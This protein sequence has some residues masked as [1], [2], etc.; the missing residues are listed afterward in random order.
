MKYISI[1]YMELRQLRYLLA[2]VRLGSVGA[3]AA[4]NFVTQPAVSLQLKKLEQEIGEKLLVRSRGRMVPTPTG[5]LVAAHAEAILRRVETLESEVHGLKGLETGHLRMGNIDA[6]S[7]YV[8]PN[9]YRAFRQRFPGIRLEIVIGDTAHL[10][11]ALQAGEIELATTTLP[12]GGGF[13]ARP[14]YRDEMV[15][16]AHPKHRLARKSRV[17]VADVAEEGVITYPENAATR[18]S[19]EDVF[20][21]NGQVLNATMSISSP[22]AMKRLTQLRLGVSILPRPIVAGEL[23]RGVLKIVPLGKVRFERVIGMVYRRLDA[24]SPPARAFLDVVDEKLPQVR[25]RR[26]P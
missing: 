3:A 13:V 16:V 19:I 2:T 21:K 23:S 24:L 18:R 9:V 17:R 5:T 10:L 26:S 15:L 8:L 20:S 14:I 7:V 22:E 25:G 6:A 11:S 12:V 1:A 4:E